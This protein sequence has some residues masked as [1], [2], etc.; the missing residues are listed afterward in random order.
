MVDRSSWWRSLP[1]SAAANLAAVWVP[2]GLPGFSGEREGGEAAGARRALRRGRLAPRDTWSAA[3]SSR[4]PRPSRSTSSRIAGSCAIAGRS[5]RSSPSTAA[6]STT[7][8]SRTSSTATTTQPDTPANHYQDI[9]VRRVIAELADD[10]AWP[11]VTPTE[12]GEVELVDLGIGRAPSRAARLRLPGRRP[13]PDP[14]AR[15]ARVH[16]Q[17]RGRAGARPGPDHDPRGPRRVVPPRGHRPPVGRGVLADEQGRRGPLRPVPRARAGSSG[18][19]S[20]P[21]A[22]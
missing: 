22:A 17:P 15:L 11:E 9:S 5:S 10:P 7:G 1:P 4:R 18:T 2:V 14:R 19:R 12:P 21:P 6:T 8:A 3:A 16:A 20:A 13:A